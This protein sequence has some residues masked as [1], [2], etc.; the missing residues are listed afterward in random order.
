M[1]LSN[2]GSQYYTVIKDKSVWNQN[3]LATYSVH[4]WPETGVFS[5]V[6]WW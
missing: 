2:E 3:Q 6:F 5:Q 4:E 1:C